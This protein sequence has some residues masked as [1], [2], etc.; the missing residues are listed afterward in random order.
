MSHSSHRKGIIEGYSSSIAHPSRYMDQKTWSTKYYPFLKTEVNRQRPVPH[1]PRMTPEEFKEVNWVVVLL[2]SHPTHI[3][4]EDV[5]RDA[6]ASK[7]LFVNF[8][9]HHTHV[10]QALDQGLFT[11]FKVRRHKTPCSRTLSVYRRPLSPKLQSAFVCLRNLGTIMICH[12]SSVL[13]SLPLTDLSS[14]M[15]S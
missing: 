6:L 8:P 5:L 12:K 2:D 9:G 7:I 15:R 13:P 1:H 11:S 10:I 14:R 3:F 4:D